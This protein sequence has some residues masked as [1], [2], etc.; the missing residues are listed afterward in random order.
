MLVT[1]RKKNRI[2]TKPKNN[3]GDIIAQPIDFTRK[4]F[5]TPPRER[6]NIHA[7]NQTGIGKTSKNAVSTTST[8]LSIEKKSCPLRGS[9]YNSNAGTLIR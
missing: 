3:A 2:K 1:T 7:I 8:T 6:S 4:L 5:S 9:I